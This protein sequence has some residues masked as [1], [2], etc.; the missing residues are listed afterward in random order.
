MGLKVKKITS[1][2]V[3]SFINSDLVNIIPLYQKS[4]QQRIHD[5]A[6]QEQ[7]SSILNRPKLNF[8]KKN[9][10]PNTCTVCR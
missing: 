5:I 8:Y 3:Y 6:L 4:T 1:I 9:Q 7:D 2:L 10:N